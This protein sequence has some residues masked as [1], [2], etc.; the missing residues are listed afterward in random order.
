MDDLTAN[1]RTLASGKKVEA[2]E[3]KE[4]QRVMN[5]I[6]QKSSPA[7]VHQPDV[8]EVGSEPSSSTATS[9]EKDQVKRIQ[10]L[11]ADC[12]KPAATGRAEQ[13]RGWGQRAE[14]KRLM[15]FIKEKTQPAYTNQNEADRIMRLIKEKESEEHQTEADRIMSLIKENEVKEQQKREKEQKD[16]KKKLKEHE[17]FTEWVAWAQGEIAQKKAAESTDEDASY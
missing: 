16:A 5:F 1:I 10:G 6:K 4:A 15:D 9:H 2:P 14:E 12:S 3:S 7:A 17:R 8:T 11:I 13:T